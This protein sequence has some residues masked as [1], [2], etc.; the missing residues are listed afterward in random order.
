MGSKLSWIIS[1][2][3]P[4]KYLEAYRVVSLVKDSTEKTQWSFLPHMHPHF[5][6]RE[7]FQNNG[8]K[9]KQEVDLIQKLIAKTQFL[10]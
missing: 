4:K 3:G 5:A 1:N 8:F 6:Y 7:H 9:R 10:H 2:L